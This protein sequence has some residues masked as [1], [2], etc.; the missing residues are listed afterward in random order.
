MNKQYQV[1]LISEGNKYRPVSTIVVCGEVD[2]TNRDE[3]KALIKRGT[4]RI[5]IKRYWGSRELKLYG[6]TKARVREYDKE[7]IEQENKE[8]Y[9]RIKEQHYQ[10]GTWKRTKNK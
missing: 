3:K 7:K 10:D 8:R 5:C 9:E 4:E 6:Y 2:L 1:T